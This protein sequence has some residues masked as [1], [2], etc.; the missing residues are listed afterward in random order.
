MNYY[1]YDTIILGFDGELPQGFPLVDSFSKRNQG[2]FPLTAEQTTYNTANVNASILQV[3]YCGNI[4]QPEIILPTLEERKQELKDKF[5]PVQ[6]LF[7]SKLSAVDSI[8]GNTHDISIR[9]R[10]ICRVRRDGTIDTI[11]GFTT[12]EQAMAF[13]IRDSDAAPM[14][15]AID[16]IESNTS[17]NQNALNTVNDI[18]TQVEEALNIN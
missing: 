15:Y 4:P 8:L 2:C 5:K 11:D 6:E 13:D 14:L 1:F 12:I 7:T 17:N 10:N 9:L 3:Y 18:L 16:I